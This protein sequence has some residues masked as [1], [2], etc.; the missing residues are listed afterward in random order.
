MG[1]PDL[2]DDQRS[3]VGYLA[4]IR[5]RGSGGTTVRTLGDKAGIS[6][7]HRLQC[8]LEYLRRNGHIVIHASNCGQTVSPQPSVVELADE[9]NAVH[10]ILPD[11]CARWLRWLKAHKVTAGIIAA[12]VA[13]GVL[14]GA[15]SFLV[16]VLGMFRFR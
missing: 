8:L 6:D 3:A 10:E 16:S 1:L 12:L 5:Q 4:A 13:A 9:L 2:A 14:Y 15:I 11:W 7:P